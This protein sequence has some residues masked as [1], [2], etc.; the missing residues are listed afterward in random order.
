MIWATWRQHRAEALIVAITL[1]ALAAL[2]IVTGLQMRAAFQSLGVGPCLAPTNTNPNCRDIVE[3]FR[4]QFQPLD[5][6]SG[7]L[8]MLPVILG[9]LVG[10]PLVA[11]ELEHRTH[12]LA[13]TQGVTRR[14]W[15]TTKLACVIG[16]AL[17][18]A[19]VFTALMI[20]WRGS[21]DQLDGRLTPISF[22]FEGLA[23]FAYTAFALALAIAAGT[24]LRHAIPAMAI[25][26]V[27]YMALR[28]PIDSWARA[29]LYEPPI[30]LNVN[31]L[32][33]GGPASADWLIDSGFVD[34]AGHAISNSQVFATCAPP[35]TISK[36]SVL[37]CV[38]AHGWLTSYVYQPAD[39][40]WRFQI[41]E[42]LL[43]LALSA[44]LL[45]LT[46]WWTRRSIR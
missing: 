1:A 10:A 43:Y 15:L 29:Y 27:G 28:L 8:N 24:L 40:F 21:F 44:A 20:W 2:L 31:P 26:L 13:W 22:D 6:A 18:A 41:T 38:Q 39:R 9:M 14:R 25:T 23:P 30:T 45:G 34:H 4:N 7:W 42:A 33:S 5:G 46:Y 3:A 36:L 19:G 17:V 32:S 35:G 37:Q 12:L 11:R 16:G